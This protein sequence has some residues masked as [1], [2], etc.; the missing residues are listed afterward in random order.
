MIRIREEDLPLLSP[1][2]ISVKKRKI[3][4]S[5]I[6]KILNIILKQTTLSP[7]V[8]NKIRE[9]LDN[10]NWVATK[11]FNKLY[12]ER[13]SVNFKESLC[14]LYPKLSQEWH[15]TK[16][17]TLLPEHFTPGAGRK[18]WWLGECGHEWQ[19]TINHRTSGRDC[20]KCRYE[21]ASRTRRKNS[22]KGQLKLL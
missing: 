1:N 19:D 10:R 22:T 8:R 11:L 21:K 16:N 2:D 13:K 3:S 17:D 15:P 20:P 14:H 7:E 18:V 6:K 5:T 4:V 9:Y 12:A